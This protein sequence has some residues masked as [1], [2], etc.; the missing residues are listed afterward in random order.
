TL[1]G[2]HAGVWPIVFTALA[3]VLIFFGKNLYK[4]LEKIMM[5]VVMIMILAF[6]VNLIFIKPDLVAVAQG[7][8]PKPFSTDNLGELAAITGTTF[9]LNSALYQSYL[10]QNKGWKIADKKKATRD[11]N[12]GIFL[13]SL[14]SIFV[15]ATAATTLKP[16]GIVV[17]SASDMALQL[18]MLLG[19][20][21]KYVFAIGFSAAA[22]SSLLV[23]AV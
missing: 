17:N 3:I 12:L 10:V 13:L 9:V 1:T 5:Y 19:S 2:I 21:A 22:F 4:V 20:Y 6:V 23:N 14:M 15:I 8:V 16:L 7:F 11:S 18:E